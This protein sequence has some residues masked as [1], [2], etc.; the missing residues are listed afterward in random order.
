MKELINHFFLSYLE[1]NPWIK[2]CVKVVRS[3]LCMQLILLQLELFGVSVLIF[4]LNLQCFFFFLGRPE[5][6]NVDKWPK[7]TRLCQTVSKN[8]HDNCE[9]SVLGQG[10]SD[11][12]A[13]SK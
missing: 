5:N 12:A 13:S 10:L 6:R 2:L 4:V 9:G 1:S 7:F 11:A 3:V 8:S